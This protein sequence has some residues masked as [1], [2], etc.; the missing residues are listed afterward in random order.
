MT[1]TCP[2]DLRACEGEFSVK[3]SFGGRHE[4]AIFRRANYQRI[5]GTG[6]GFLGEGNH[7]L[8][9]Y[10]GADPLSLEVEVR[11]HGGF[12]REAAARA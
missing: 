10:S 11:Q 5:E 1:L 3:L 9:R 6:C 4:E 2:Q 7:P 12:G 8:A